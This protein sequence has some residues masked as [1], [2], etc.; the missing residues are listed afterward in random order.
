M[1]VIVMA[2][3]VVMPVRKGLPVISADRSAEFIKVSNENMMSKER[4]SECAKTL[5][6]FKRSK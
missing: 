1:E 3:P 5:S 2:K 4:L 6:K